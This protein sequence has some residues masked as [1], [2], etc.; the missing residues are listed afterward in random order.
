M[1]VSSTESIT[2]LANADDIALLGDGF[3][4]VQDAL[5]GVERYAV[6]VSLRIN[7]A[8]TKVLSVQ[9]TAS[10]QRQLFPEG[11]PLEEVA[12]FMYLGASFTATVQAVQVIESRINSAR[13]AFNRLHTALWSRLEISRKT[14]SRVYTAV[15]RSSLL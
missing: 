5:E 2:D 8:K 13:M 4:A 12:T 3:E 7:T 11:V 14:K 10:Q 9:V 1:Q 15:V 6:A